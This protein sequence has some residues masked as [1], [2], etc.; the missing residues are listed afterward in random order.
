[1]NVPGPKLLEDEKFTQDLLGVCTPTFVTPNVVVNARLHAQSLKRTP[2]FYFARPPI[3]TE[4]VLHPAKYIA[5]EKPIAVRVPSAIAAGSKVALSRTMGELG[6]RL[7]LLSCMDARQVDINGW[8]GD[9]LTLL[10]RQGSLH[11]VL[12]STVLG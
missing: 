6:I 10:E 7:V 3:S 4:Q 2:L 8:G 5:G 12:W 1:M 11:E 9:R